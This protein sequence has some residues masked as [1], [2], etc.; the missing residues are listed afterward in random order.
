MNKPT[1]PKEMTLDGAFS[2]LENYDEDD[3]TV[4][5]GHIS[6]VHEVPIRI[7][8]RPIPSVLDERKVESL[9]VT[10]QVLHTLYF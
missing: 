2:Q 10:I 7:L 8:I 5:A 3:Y 9:M 6:E 4:H 1:A